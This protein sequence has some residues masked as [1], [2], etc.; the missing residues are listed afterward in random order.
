METDA[1]IMRYIRTGYYYYYYYYYYLL[2]LLL[3]NTTA[4]PLD[5]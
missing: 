5:K 1:V 2:L 4:F 3:L